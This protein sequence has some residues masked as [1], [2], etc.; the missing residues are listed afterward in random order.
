M[1]APRSVAASL[2]K[3]ARR[4]EAVPD[5]AVADAA[6]LTID[7]AVALGGRFGRGH[8]FAEAVERRRRK[9]RSSVLMWAKPAGAWSIKSYG[10]RGGYLVAPRSR[11]LG[12]RGRSVLRVPGSPTGFAAHTRPGASSGDRRWD[13]VVE[14]VS[15]EFD[16]LVGEQVGA[17]IDG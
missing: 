9:G 4:L 15:A 17:A 5:T 1:A 13:R 6:R 12:R 10:R 2:R 11:R 16:D 3:S 14:V 8:L 7:E